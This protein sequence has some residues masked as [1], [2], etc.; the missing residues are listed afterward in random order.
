MNLCRRQVECEDLGVCADAVV[1][2]LRSLGGR[3]VPLFCSASLTSSISFR[4]VL[5][6]ENSMREVST[7]DLGRRLVTFLGEPVEG[8]TV[9]QSVTLAGTCTHARCNL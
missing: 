2:G 6:A 3:S 4:I 8:R 1:K 5:K 9:S 7:C